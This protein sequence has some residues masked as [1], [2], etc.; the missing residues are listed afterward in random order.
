[1]LSEEFTGEF[2]PIPPGMDEDEFEKEEVDRY[3]HDISS[4]DDSYENIEYVEASPLNLEYDS[5]E[6][7]NEDQE[8]KEFDLEDIFQIQDV[9]LREKLLNVHRLI[10]NIESLKNN[11]TPDFV[12]KSPS[13]FPILVV[14][15]DSFFEV[16]DTSLSHSGNSLPEFKSFSDHTEK[17]RSGS[18]TIHANYSL[19]EGSEIDFYPNVEEDDTFTLSIRTFLPFVTYPE[20]SPLSCST[21]SEDTIFDTG[22]FIYHFPYLEP[23]DRPNFSEDSRVRCFVPVHSS[24]LAFA[25][26]RSDC[27][28]ILKVEVTIEELCRADGKEW[29]GAYRL[30]GEAQSDEEIFFSVS[31]V[32]AFNIRE[33]IYP[34]LCHKFYA[35]YEFDE[36]CADDELQRLRLYHAQELEEEGFDTYFQGGLRSDENFNAREYWERISIDLDLHLFR[37]SITSVRFPILRVLH[38]M[39]TY[40]LCHRTTGYEKIQRNDLWLK[41]TGSQKDSQICCGQFILK[42][43][44]KSRVLTEETI[45]SLSTLVYCRDLDMTTLR[46]LITSK[47]RLIPEI[48]VDDIPRVAA[49]RAPRVQ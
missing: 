7:E 5:L 36:V 35:T 37:S 17:T 45:R 23:V 41:G 22:I 32:R 43:A 38:K 44:K 49:Q 1:F 29:I 47:D 18:T 12:F 13:S 30:C 2:A 34:E 33:P 39:I 27:G 20:V 4:D 19:P 6:E 48:Q 26:H 24:F 16:S 15:S 8:E 21:G 10:T 11:P 9:I 42:I 28:W 14:D 3:D 25:C 31:W 46:E 40:G